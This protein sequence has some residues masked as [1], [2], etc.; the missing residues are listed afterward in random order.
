MP[1]KTRWHPRLL[2]DNCQRKLRQD[3][4]ESNAI[5]AASTRLEPDAELEEYDDDNPQPRMEE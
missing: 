2:P 5:A 4:A 3:L 1:Q